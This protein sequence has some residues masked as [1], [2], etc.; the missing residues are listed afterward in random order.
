[1]VAVK[2]LI[3]PMILMVVSLLINPYG[4]KAITC[5]FY[6]STISLLEIDELQ[7]INIFSEQMI[8]FMVGIIL[9]V[10]LY[11][12]NKLT[13]TTFYFTIGTGVLFTIAER[14]SIFYSVAILYS[15]KDLLKKLKLNRFYDFLNSTNKKEEKIVT[16]VTFASA[17]LILLLLV[18]KCL[19]NENSNSSN[20]NFIT[21][22]KAVKYLEQNE[23]DLSKI[24]MFTEF[25]SGSFFLWN[26]IGKIYFEPK[27][28]PYIEEINGVKDIVTEYA[29]LKKCATYE[30]IKK[31]LNE[32]D[33]DY[34]YVPAMF[35]SLQ[36]YLESS[37]EYECVVVGSNYE[38]LTNYED[39]DIAQYRL[40]KHI[41]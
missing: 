6:S 35:T 13:S 28:E 38:G 31:F 16:G 5:L 25:N 9:C 20:D 39:Y 18:N 10:M 3:I 21:P 33:F 24:R 37:D 2:P 17:I 1:V 22:S 8:Y 4:I 32:Y 41:R 12:K 34:L 7:Q 36:V 26:G 11:V 15:M 27:T 40:Y 29:Y 30:D 14:N 19:N 23:E